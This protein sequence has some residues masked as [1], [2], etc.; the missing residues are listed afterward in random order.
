MQAARTV[1]TRRRARSA[2]GS[3]S[4][5]A[6]IRRCPAFAVLVCVLV[7]AG[8]GGDGDA[9]QGKSGGTLRIAGA[10]EFAGQ[11][12]HDYTGDF[13]LVDMVYEPLV[14]YGKDGVLEPALAKAWRVSDDG[15]QVTFDLREGVTFH[16]GTP[17]DAKAAKW[18]FDRW[19]GKERHDFFATSTVIDK[20]EATDPRTLTLTLKEP[21]EPLLQ[22][23]TFAR[24]VRFLSPASAGSDGAFKKPVGTGP[25]RLRSSS[26]TAATLVRNAGYWGRKPGPERVEFKVLKDS[27]TRVSALRSGEVD[28][29]G[30]SY[31]SPITPT[32]ATELKG[33][34]GVTLLQGRPDVTVLVGFN[35]KGVAG[36]RAVREAVRLALDRTALTRVLFS[37][38]ATPATTL[39]APGVPDGGTAQEMRF[40]P[41][42]ARRL[43]DRAGWGERDGTR[44]KGGRPLRLSLLISSSPVHGQQDARLSAEALADSLAKVGVD[45]RIKPVDEAAYFDERTAGRY[46][47]A[48]FETYGAP[49]DPSGF[50]VGFLTTKGGGMLW[51]SPAID[52]LVDEAL[53]ARDDGARAQAYQRVYDVLDRDAAFVPIAYRPRLWAVRS[54]VKGFVVPDTEYELDLSR[55]TLGG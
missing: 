11:D 30:G 31:N 17:F 18:N 53:F 46:D 8:C 21:Y 12:P 24:P 25:W 45:V 36:D 40:D 22:E 55:V 6:L 33:A 15:L 20:V 38:L 44:T 26:R 2:A 52:R 9:G 13:I 43:L 4:G 32:E 7:I 35:A 48:F 5:V 50:V 29:I 42:E 39:F 54:N 23:L 16:D 28:M 51:R 14:R 49:Y 41:G 3:G 19:V 37:G 27:Q 47:L 34:A 10:S 1:S